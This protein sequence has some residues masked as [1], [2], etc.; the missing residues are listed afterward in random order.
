M[1]PLVYRRKAH[2]EIAPVLLILKTKRSRRLFQRPEEDET[3]KTVLRFLNARRVTG[4]KPGLSEIK[5][6]FRGQNLSQHY[7]SP[8]IFTS[9]RFLRPPS[10]S[11]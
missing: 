5:S 10:N 3:V 1:A 9:T 11:P 7:Y 6:D 8:M 2:D 4:L